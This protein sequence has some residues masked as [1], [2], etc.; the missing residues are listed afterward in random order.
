MLQEF[1]GNDELVGTLLEN[2]R[3]K[4]EEDIRRNG[5]REPIHVWW[6]ASD[7]KFAVVAGNERLRIIRKFDSTL[8]RALNLENPPAIVKKFDSWPEARA[9]VVAVN[10]NRKRTKVAPHDKLL[11]YFPPAEYPVLYTNLTGNYSAETVISEVNLPVGKFTLPSPRKA[12]EI[13][14]M[15]KAILSEACAVTGF[16]EPFVRKQLSLIM[17][18]WSKGQGAQTAFSDKQK[19]EVAAAIHSLKKVQP[20]IASL[21]EKIARLKK[22]ESRCLRTLRKYRLDENGRPIKKR[23]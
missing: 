9:H 14:E 15:K 8:R 7:E 10:E 4:L 20:Q 16:T 2:D 12:R 23:L 18:R 6:I 17:S 5:L 22:I 11:R 3:I 1:P 13:A 21:N 19:K